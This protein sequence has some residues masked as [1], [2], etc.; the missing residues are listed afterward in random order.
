[1]VIFYIFRNCLPAN[2][3]SKESFYKIPLIRIDLLLSII[4]LVIMI[5]NIFCSKNIKNLK[6]SNSSYLIFTN[7]GDLS[8][9]DAI[10]SYILY[11]EHV[12]N[13]VPINFILDTIIISLPFILLF[14]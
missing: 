13:L 9:Q 7:Y 1:M 5:P 10:N 4:M 6:N 8:F 2:I 11:I 14:C 3:S 12:K